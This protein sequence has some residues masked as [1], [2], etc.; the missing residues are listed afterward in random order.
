MKR[1]GIERYALARDDVRTALEF[2]LSEAG[3][4]VALDFLEEIDNAL[5]YIAEFPM[6]GSPRLGQELGLPGVRSWSIRRFPYLVFYL[7]AGDRV[8]VWRILHVQRDLPNT[9]AGLG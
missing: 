9:L 2:Y 7:D 1:R 8:V 6:S 5:T 3:D 4:A